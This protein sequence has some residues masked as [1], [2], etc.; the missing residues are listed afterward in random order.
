MLDLYHQPYEVNRHMEGFSREACEE[1][2]EAF[3]RDR[4]GSIRLSLP[5]GPQG[6]RV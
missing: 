6:L 3:F 5:W 4:F 1:V 2:A